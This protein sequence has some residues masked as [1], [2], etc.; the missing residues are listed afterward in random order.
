MRPFFGLA[1]FFTNSGD[2]LSGFLPL[3]F[4]PDKRAHRTARHPSGTGLPECPGQP[5]AP[6]GGPSVGP[7]IIMVR[8]W[9]SRP[10]PHLLWRRDCRAVAPIECLASRSPCILLDFLPIFCFSGAKFLRIP[11][12][13]PHAGD[14]PPGHFSGSGRTAAWISLSSTV[15]GG[16]S[17]IFR[18]FRAVGRMVVR[19]GV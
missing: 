19:V 6:V 8:R 5:N 11:I 14:G 7:N 9:P 18:V 12:R 3:T 2:W 10:Q 15:G 16:K 13:W 4:H 17:I 1:G